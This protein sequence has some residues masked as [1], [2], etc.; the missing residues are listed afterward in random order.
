MYANDTNSFFSSI[1]VDDLFPDMKCE[2]NKTSPEFKAN[3]LSLNL[4][5]TEYSLEDE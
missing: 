5:K 1:N 4:T 2:L 3:K